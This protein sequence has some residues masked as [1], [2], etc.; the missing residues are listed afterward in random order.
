VRPIAAAALALAAAPALAFDLAGVELGSS[1]EALRAQHARAPDSCTAEVCVFQQRLGDL[2]GTV[3]V[4]GNDAGQVAAIQVVTSSAVS[5]ALYRGAVE[6]WGAP[7]TAHA[8]RAQNV[9]GATYP[10]AV[11][12]WSKGGARVQ[13]VERCGDAAHSCLSLELASYRAKAPRAKL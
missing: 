3:R 2:L 9:A 12:A 4:H 1:Y 10:A 6:R 7:T 11:A 13:F 5:E 8:G